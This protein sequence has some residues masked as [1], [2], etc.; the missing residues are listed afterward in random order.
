MITYS[1]SVKKGEKILL[2]GYGF[3]SFPLIKELYREALKAGAIQVDVRFS[4]DELS[5]VFYELATEKQL[6]HITPLDKQVAKSYDAMIQVVADSDVYSLTDTDI[7]KLN[8]SQ[9][10]LK[11]ISD[12]LHK[13][14]WCLFYYPTR[15]FAQT[16]KKRLGEWEDFVMNCC[17]KDWKKEE[18][19]QKKFVDIMKKVKEVHVTGEETDLT[20]SIKGQK[21]KTCYGKYNMP[22]GEIFSSPVKNAV[23]GVIKYNVPTRYRSKDFEWIKLWFKNGKIVKEKASPN[24]KDL[25]DILNTDK[26]SR[27]VGECAFG[28]NDGVKEATRLIIFDEKMGKSMHMAMGRCYDECPNGNNS[29]VHWDMIFN[30]KWAKAQVYFDGKLVYDKT[31]WVDKRLGFLN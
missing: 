19:K 10:A 2:K 24:T 23:N 11:P 25:T 29:V 20:Y 14:K 18:A 15:A 31:K 8:M 16:A 30:F 6:K 5:Q 17:I 7:K 21:W 27:Y 3:E 9:K 4:H 1:I 12:I 26:G 28:L 22:D 13:R